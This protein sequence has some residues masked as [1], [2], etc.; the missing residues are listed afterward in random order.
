LKDEEIKRK[1]KTYLQKFLPIIFIKGPN[2][3]AADILFKLSNLIITV[4]LANYLSEMMT[5]Y[6]KGMVNRVE[7]KMIEKIE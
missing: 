1:K 3:S 6:K 2:L 7:L 4:K 5:Y